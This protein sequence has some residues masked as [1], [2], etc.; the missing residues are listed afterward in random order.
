MAARVVRLTIITDFV[1]ANCYVTQHELLSAITHCKDDLN[2]PLTF[3]I[4]QRPFKLINS[5]CL[6]EDSPKVDKKTFLTKWIGREQFTKLELAISKW[7]EEKGIPINFHGVMSQSTRAHRLCRKAYKIGG[8]QL[9]LPLVCALFKAYLEDGQDIADNTV[10]ADVSQDVGMM[11]RNEALRFLESDELEKEVDDMCAVARSKGVTGVPITII[12]G[13]WAV[14]GG[15]SADV[16]IQIFKKLA[17]AGVC[18]RMPSGT[19]E[20]EICT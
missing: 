8:Q 12:D 5:T 20:T 11:S 3:E 15:Q 2:L 4:E 7:A 17:T 10:L 18:P 9:Q 6:A 13:K 1:C 14:T 16:Y 19:V